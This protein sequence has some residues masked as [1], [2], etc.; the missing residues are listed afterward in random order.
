MRIPSESLVTR[1]LGW[2][3][4]FAALTTAY[5]GW[6]GVQYQEGA[7]IEAGGFDLGV[8]FVSSLIFFATYRAL[9]QGVYAALDRLARTKLLHGFTYWPDAWSEPP[10]STEPKPGDQPGDA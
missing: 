1:I 2:I 4:G 10:E 3:T 5:T 9:S 7:R 6:T 8:V